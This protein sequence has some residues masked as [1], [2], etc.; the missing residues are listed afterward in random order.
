MGQVLSALIGAAGAIIVCVIQAHTTAQ[1][2]QAQFDKA[3]SLIEYKIDELSARVEK[4]NKLVERTYRLEEAAS[5]QE[6]KIKIVNHRLD[7][8]GRK[9]E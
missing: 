6:E 7:E 9:G 5:L 8:I 1:K 3:L 2:Q 4:H